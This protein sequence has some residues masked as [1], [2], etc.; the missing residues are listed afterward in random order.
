MEED[1]R[2]TRHRSGSPTEAVAGK[3]TRLKKLVV[4]L[5]LEKAMLQDVVKKVVDPS[6]KRAIE[7]YPK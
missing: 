2:L 3:N 7:D 1:I 4:E 6:P 5:T